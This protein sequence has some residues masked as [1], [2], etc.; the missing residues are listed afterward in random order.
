MN[1]D[2]RVAPSALRVVTLLNGTLGNHGLQ[3]LQLRGDGFRPN[4]NQRNAL[5]VH[6]ARALFLNLPRQVLA[7]GALHILPCGLQYSAAGAGSCNRIAA[8][9]LRQVLCGGCCFL[10]ILPRGNVC[11]RQGSASAASCT[12]CPAGKY[13]TL[14]R[15]P[16][17][18]PPAQAA[19]EAFPAAAPA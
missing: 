1:W 15:E 2:Q 8:P 3:T 5:R 9:A 4:E 16:P 10:H 13:S 18:A 6:S 12:S 19:R 14:R 17:P 11:W 7:A